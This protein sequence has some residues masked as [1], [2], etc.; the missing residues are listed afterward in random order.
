MTCCSF[1]ALQGVGRFREALHS[2]D[3][4]NGWFWK[5]LSGQSSKILKIVD[6]VHIKM[7][8]L[9]NVKEDDENDRDDDEA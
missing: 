8:L 2:H 1:L 5:L 7:T 9:I 4:Y 3:Q 6:I